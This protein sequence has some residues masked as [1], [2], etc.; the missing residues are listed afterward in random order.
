MIN[1]HDDLEPDESADIIISH[2]TEG[3]DLAKKYKLPDRIIDFIRTHHGDSL[4]YYFYTKYAS[5]YPEEEVNKKKFQYKGPK[6]FSKETAILM[7]CD[8]IEAASKSLKN[9]TSLDFEKLVNTIIDKQLEHGQFNNAE[10][11]LKEIDKIKKV[12]TKRLI[13]IYHVRIEYPD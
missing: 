5:K 1:P 6:P 9:P 11:S 12:L 8:S 4:V 13:N 10:I 2:I 3:I 7:M